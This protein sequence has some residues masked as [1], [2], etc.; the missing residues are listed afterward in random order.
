MIRNRMGTTHQAN[1]SKM[2]SKIY[3]VITLLLQNV[4]LHIYFCISLSQR[5][6]CYFR[7]P[8]VLYLYVWK[9]GFRFSLGAYII[10]SSQF[11]LVISGDGWQAIKVMCTLFSYVVSG[12]SR[13]SNVYLWDSLFV[14]VSL[15]WL[16]RQCSFLKTGL[17]SRVECISSTAPV[18]TH[19][20]V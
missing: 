20:S 17:F 6:C 4:S 18:D 19:K 10:L 1:Y 7:R 8:K 15:M 14:P 9:R 2:S 3:R 5:V 13:W 16:S 12:T 11:S